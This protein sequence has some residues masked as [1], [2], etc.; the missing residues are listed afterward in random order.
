MTA[1]K[2]L[3]IP[4][5]LQ[6][7]DTVAVVS[8]SWGGPGTFPLR[9]EAGKTQLV[10]R[11]GLRVVEMKHTRK[12][13][14]WLERN[15]QARAD[16]LMAAFA[17]PRIKGIFAS[18]GGSDSIRLW[19]YMDLS[20][21]RNNPKIYCGYSDVT[22]THFMC[23]QAGI[24]SYY[25]A[26][27]MVEFAENGGMHEYTADS[28]TRTLFTREL[29]GLIETSAR[30]TDEHLPW[31]NPANQLVKRRLTRNAGLRVLQGKGCATGYA[32]PMCADLFPML[33]GTPMWPKPSAFDGAVLFLETSE[34]APSASEFSYWLRNMGV[35]GIFDRLS[36]IVLARPKGVKKDLHRYDTALTHIVREEFGHRTLPLLAQADF[37]HTAPQFMIPYGI[38]V[39]V[40]C[41]QGGALRFM[42]AGVR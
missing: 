32:L 17:D 9:Y 30:W 31:E 4:A 11:F 3:K 35:Q 26:A 22:A 6:R 15:P 5:A 28:V 7:G 39:E 23:L 27:V 20:V 13:A 19:P 34:D 36:A 1:L 21:I 40:D 24:R 14:A 10:E 41:R 25:G 37:G 42:E 29:I 12:P 38:K 2:R 18:I 33:S 16:D 8:P